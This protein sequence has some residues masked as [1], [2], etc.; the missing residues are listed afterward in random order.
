[1]VKR[2]LMVD[3]SRTT[4]DMVAFTLTRSGYRV[5]QAGDG[6]AA[7]AALKAEP[8]DLVITDLKMPGMDGLSLIR[9]LREQAVY[10]STPILMLSTESDGALKAEGSK[11]GATQ[12]LEKPFH[13]N[14]LSEMV[15]RLMPAV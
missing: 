14:Q 10:A 7:L 3:D 15:G 5:V 1:M 9:A 13:P 6:A 2:I 11:A 4:R 12:W 8:V